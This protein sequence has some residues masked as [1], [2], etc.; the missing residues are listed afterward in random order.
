[1]TD[2]G[3]DTSCTASAGLRSGRS[4]TGARL[5]AEALER[6]LSTTRGTLRGG[7]DEQNY[8]INLSEEIGASTSPEALKAKIAAECRKDER[9]EQVDVVVLRTSEGPAVTY[10]ITVGGYAAAGPFT[11]RL[12]VSEVSAELLGIE[13]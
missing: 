7:P 6:R 2:Y 11:L 5:V 1:M 12:S 8:G 9:V 4:S 3:R 10:T 13:A